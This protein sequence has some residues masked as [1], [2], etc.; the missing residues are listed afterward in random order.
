MHV[1]TSS[2]DQNKLLAVYEGTWVV[3]LLGKQLLLLLLVQ[4]ITAA[5]IAAANGR[6]AAQCLS[7]VCQRLGEYAVEQ[8]RSIFASSAGYV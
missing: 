2:I 3:L 5:S 7:E 8:L 4:A 6:R 1:S